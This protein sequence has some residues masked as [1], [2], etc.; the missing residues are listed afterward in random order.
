MAQFRLYR[1]KDW[2]P[3]LHT[4]ATALEH[5]HDCITKANS[6]DAL[7]EAMDALESAR[8]AYGR[9]TLKLDKERRPLVY[10]K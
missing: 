6:I 10:A 4:A 2:P 5:A 8:R 1:A 9:E 3:A 7:D